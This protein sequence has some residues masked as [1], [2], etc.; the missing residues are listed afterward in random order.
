MKKEKIERA[1]MEVICFEEADVIVTSQD[2]STGT[3]NND[4]IEEVNVDLGDDDD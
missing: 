3:F 2:H 1:A 4:S